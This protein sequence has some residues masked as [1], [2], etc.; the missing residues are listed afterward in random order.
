MS[1][2]KTLAAVTLLV[3]LWVLY[4]IASQPTDRYPVRGSVLNPSSTAVLLSE[5]TGA[6]IDSIS[7]LFLEVY[8]EGEAPWTP[9][10]L[11]EMNPRLQ[12]YE[13]P[14]LWDDDVDCPIPDPL[15]DPFVR[16]LTIYGV[17]YDT[18]AVGGK[19][20]KTSAKEWAR[21]SPDF[22]SLTDAGVFSMRCELGAVPLYLIGAPPR[23]NYIPHQNAVPYNGPV[24]LAPQQAV[25]NAWCTYFGDTLRVTVGRMPRYSQLEERIR[26]RRRSLGLPETYRSQSLADRLS[27]PSVNINL[28]DSIARRMWVRTMVRSQEFFAKIVATGRVKMFQF[29]RYH[30]IGWHSAENIGGLYTGRPWTVAYNE[31]RSKAAAALQPE[32]E[33]DRAPARCDDLLDQYYKKRGYLTMNSGCPVNCQEPSAPTNQAKWLL[34]HACNRTFNDKNWMPHSQSMWDYTQTANYYCGSLYKGYHWSSR[35][36]TK[37]GLAFGR[38]AMANWKEFPTFTFN[39]VWD[40]HARMVTPFLSHI[41]KYAA[42]GFENMEEQFYDRFQIVMSDHGI[43]FGAHLE[44]REG[45]VEHKLPLFNLFV[46]TLWLEKHPDAAQALEE[47]QNKFVTAFDLHATLEH[48]PLL[49]PPSGPIPVP[50]LPP[51]TWQHARSLFL[52]IDKSR[53][54]Q[55]VGLPSSYCVCDNQGWVDVDLGKVARDY[56][57]VY[58]Q[59]VSIAVARMNRVVAAETTASCMQLHPKEIKSIRQKEFLKGRGN[60]KNPYAGIM[61]RETLIHFTV[62]PGDA[63]FEVAM[64]E[65]GAADATS[66]GELD[67]RVDFDGIHRLTSMTAADHEAIGHLPGEQ[68]PWCIG[69][70]TPETSPLA[71][72]FL[73]ATDKSL[74][75]KAVVNFQKPT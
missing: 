15:P 73:T 75:E 74:L 31:G 9:S 24:Q 70:G 62:T 28:F 43:H 69:A 27:P 17:E 23:I 34:K 41:D 38:S 26:S 63:L 64:F 32:F 71:T 10:F 22:A 65:R 48:L 3:L 8:A 7:S 59:L 5:Q 30:V 16:N 39:Y 67:G 11:G 1:L 52:P 54:C 19:V 18:T 51:Q 45:Q 35:L 57:N 50:P 4:Y 47:N 33:G 37:H 68:A 44:S 20:W 13:E 66:V 2:R 53:N 61:S 60:K 55:T 42:E 72:F 58:N 6:L 46:P 49:D 14:Y 40:I 29:R 25:V 12:L 56:Q 21:H 36:C